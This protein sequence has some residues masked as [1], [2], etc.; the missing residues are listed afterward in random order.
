[1]KSFHFVRFPDPECISTLIVK[2]MKMPTTI[3]SMNIIIMTCDG[4]NDDDDD[5]NNNNNNDNNNIHLDQAQNQRQ[6]DK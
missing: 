1:M 2:I 5:N 4:R 6:P 3:S